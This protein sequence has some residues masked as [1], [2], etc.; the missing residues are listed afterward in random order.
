MET[1]TLQTIL[2][3]FEIK[4]YFSITQVKKF[5]EKCL[6]K[7]D[8]HDDI[9]DDSGSS[10]LSKDDAY[11]L[12]KQVL[13]SPTDGTSGDYHDYA[14]AFAEFDNYTD[15]CEVLLMGLKKY[16]ADVNLLSDFLLYATKSSKNEHYERCEEKYE[17]LKTR[18]AIWNWRAYDFSFEYLLDKLNRGIGDIEG[19]RAE[20]LELAQKFQ[21]S[22]PDNELGYIDEAVI[23]ATFREY[24]KEK[25]ALEKAYDKK[26]IPIVRAG[27]S[28]ARIYLREK[29][30]DMAMECL[31]R[32]I[33]DIPSVDSTISPARVLILLIISKI[34]KFLSGWNATLPPDAGQKILVKEI[35]EDWNRAKNSTTTWG[36]KDAKGLVEFV[37]AISGESVDDD[38]V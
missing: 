36:Y 10:Q 31:V 12:V 3:E 4:G 14:V 1:E 32:A 29:K 37:K 23:Y 8:E 26:N 6:Q 2:N 19:L 22:I 25:S 27:I 17:L 9:D 7:K 35:I 34:A 15:T 33:K 13:S 11:K 24:D 20:C 30:P 16:R 5:T 38:D 18:Y 28:L 21:A